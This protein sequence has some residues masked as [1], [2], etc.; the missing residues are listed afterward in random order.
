MGSVHMETALTPAQC[1]FMQSKL[2]QIAELHKTG[3]GIN[4]ILRALR[5]HEAG[6][7]NKYNYQKMATC[8]YCGKESPTAR[9]KKFCNIDCYGKYHRRLK[10]DS[11]TTG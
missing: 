5:R 6:Y 1:D 10:N 9:D 2:R 11:C 3:A 8:L 4:D 7:Y